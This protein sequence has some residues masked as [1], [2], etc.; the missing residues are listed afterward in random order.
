M[1][2]PS[3][4]PKPPPID[5][6]SP[7]SRAALTGSARLSFCR[8]HHMKLLSII[9]CTLFLVGCASQQ[10]QVAQNKCREI[11]PGMTRAQ[12]TNSFFAYSGGFIPSAAFHQHQT[13]AYRS[14]DRIKIDV[15]F[16]P[17]DSKVARP[18]DVIAKVSEPYLESS[19]LD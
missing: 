19:L 3:N 1:M 5:G 6:M 9:V 12:L 14:Y 8:R 7:H 13:Y 4:S 2:L 10:Q 11:R 16:A 18:T 15:D 17:S